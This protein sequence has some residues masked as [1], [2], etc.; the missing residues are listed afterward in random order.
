MDQCNNNNSSPDV[1][2][3]KIHVTFFKNEFASTLTTMDMTLPELR[4]LILKTKGATKGA[5]PWLKGARFGNKPKP[6]DDGTDGTCLRW[7]TT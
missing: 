7:T 1:A 6:K 3:H 2:L 4:D 5:L